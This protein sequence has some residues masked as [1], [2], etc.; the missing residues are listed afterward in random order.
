MDMEKREEEE[1]GN[2]DVELEGAVK[3][4]GFEY[5]QQPY[6]FLIFFKLSSET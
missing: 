4:S 5:T 6:K 3:K 2:E 1:Q